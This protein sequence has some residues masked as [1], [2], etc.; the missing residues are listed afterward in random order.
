MIYRARLSCPRCG[1]VEETTIGSLFD[2]PHINCGD[3]LMRRVEVVEMTLDMTHA[4][5]KGKAQ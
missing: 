1:K 2:R 4:T 5:L 3:C